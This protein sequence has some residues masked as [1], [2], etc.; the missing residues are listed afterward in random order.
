MLVRS[1]RRTDSVQGR[2]RIVKDSAK[3]LFI[4]LLAGALATATRTAGAAGFVVVAGDDADDIHHCSYIPTAAESCG[5]LYP[6]LL[7]RAIATSSTGSGDILV[8]GANA[9]HAQTAINNWNAPANGGPG[10]TLV[11]A[12][13]TAVIDA[14]DFADY[15]AV[16]IA[17]VES[18]TPGGLTSAQLTSLN[19]RAADISSYVNTHG[20][21]LLALTEEGATGAWGWLPVPLT[22]TEA[23]FDGAA[24]TA[25]LTAL[26]PGT[27][28]ANLSH[29]CFHNVFTG[30]PGFSGL[31]VLAVATNAPA[32]L[33]GLPVMLGGLGTIITAEVCDDGVDND[34]DG[35]VDNADPDCHVCG[36]GDLDPLEQCDDGNNVSGDGCDATCAI[37][38]PDTDGDGVCDEVDTCPDVANPDQ[39][40]GDGDGIGDACDNCLT[41]ANADQADSD[42]DLTGDACDACPLD[43]ANDADGD[44]VCGDVDVCPGTAASDLA[45][46]V[47]SVALGTNRWADLDGDGVFD[48]RPPNGNGPSLSFTI[49]DTAGCNCAQ[50]IIALGLGA[51]HVKHGCSISA[52]QTW[53]SLLSP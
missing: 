51:G 21:S 13:S 19:G 24:P 49:E 30:P 23:D 45:A 2:R 34:G 31:D 14:I 15:S 12:N 42:G 43:P 4:V 20:G 40:D 29:C 3:T 47:P 41:V 1:G 36:D 32:P 33:N 18:H 9:G 25:D 37:E 46:G 53:I 35:L 5:G 50:I 27:T 39:A 17:S 6:A 8:I 28:A 22:T 44:G 26:S 11:F 7:T 48:T 38:C 10:A 16:Y 52:M